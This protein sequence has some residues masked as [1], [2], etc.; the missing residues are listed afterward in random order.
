MT[1]TTYDFITIEEINNTL[2]ANIA[3]QLQQYIQL[4]LKGEY[5]D[6]FIVCKL[7]PK[8][9]EELQTIFELNEALKQANYIPT[10]LSLIDNTKEA[11]PYY[12]KIE[13]PMVKQEG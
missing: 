13:W 10:L 3:L 8:T 2:T 5:T 11:T 1:K 12:L 9:Q 7:I 4:N 6:N